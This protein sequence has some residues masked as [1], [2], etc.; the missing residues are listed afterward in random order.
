VRIRA[1]VTLA[2][3][4]S[5]ET[6]AEP[7]RKPPET[8]FVCALLAGPVFVPA[9]QALLAAAVKHPC[10]AS[11]PTCC[12]L[13]TGTIIGRPVCKP[14]SSPRQ[15]IF[16]GA[17]ARPRELVALATFYDPRKK[18]F[19]RPPRPLSFRGRWPTMTI[20]RALVGS[21]CFCRDSLLLDSLGLNQ[22]LLRRLRPFQCFQWRRLLRR[23]SRLRSCNGAFG[24]R[25]RSLRC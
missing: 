14:S 1:F 24:K 18:A 8:I 20:V 19:R 23:A 13:L 17:S 10:V 6:V 7:R 11:T 21:L 16:E 15:L 25:R 9:R 4:I 3:F 2:S 5:Q 22:D 12:W